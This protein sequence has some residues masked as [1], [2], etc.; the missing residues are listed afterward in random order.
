MV[1]CSVMNNYSLITGASGY[2]ET[3]ALTQDGVAAAMEGA[4]RVALAAQ[5][6]AGG[7]RRG[8]RLPWRRW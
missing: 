2:F 6:S 7:R 8:F 1:H 3:S 5:A 4:I